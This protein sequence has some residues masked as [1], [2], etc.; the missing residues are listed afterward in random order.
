MSARTRQRV[1]SVCLLMLACGARSSLPIDGAEGGAGQTTGGGGLGGGGFGAEGGEG[2]QG[3]GVG[4]VEQ[5]ALG[6]GHSCLRAFDGDVY[7]WGRN[8]KGQLGTG[9]T[10]DSLEPVK[11]ELPEPATFLSAGSFHTCALLLSGSV[12]CWGASEFGQALPQLGEQ[13]AIPTPAAVEGLFGEVT[14]LALGEG[15]SCA[16]T[17]SA[18]ASTVRCWGVGFTP[19]IS[20]GIFDGGVAAAAG[21]FFT[22][23]LDQA[24]SVSCVGENGQGQCGVSAPANVTTPA[25]VALP[26]TA[27]SVKAGRGNHACATSAVGETACWG[28]NDSGQLGDGSSSEFS[29]PLLVD[30][31]FEQVAPGFVHTCGLREGQVACWGSNSSGQLGTAGPSSPFPVTISGLSNVVAVGTGT[32]HSCAYVSPTELYCWGGNDF[33]QLGIGTTDSTNVPSLVQLP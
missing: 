21:A 10:V 24:G 15:H 29:L 7:C 8:S 27:V 11:A 31:S 2:G 12:Y 6:A 4:G 13:T 25:Q 23:S 17:A 26:F 16:V 9:D 30:G 20:E 22:C 18:D 32:L 5:L 1:S 14:S 33:G 28:D 19:P 3:G